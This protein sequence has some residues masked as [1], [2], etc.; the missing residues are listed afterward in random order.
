VK[1]RE[2]K[3]L[4][5]SSESTEQSDRPNLY[6]SSFISARGTRFKDHSLTQCPTLFSMATVNMNC[7]E[8]YNPNPALKASQAQLT[9]SVLNKH[10]PSLQPRISPPEDAGSAQNVQDRDSLDDSLLSLD[11]LFQAFRNGDIP[12]V[13]HQNHKPLHISKCQLIDK[14]RLQR[15]PT[16]TNSACV[17]GNTQS[18]FLS[19]LLCSYS[20]R[21]GEYRSDQNPDA[22]SE[23]GGRRP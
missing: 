11:E 9:R 23:R 15:N 21:T 8:F 3:G 12:Q 18:R 16:T 5:D 7:A 19:L 2:A 1:T 20:A 17:P 22:L 6:I 14:D 10:L 13:P 4:A